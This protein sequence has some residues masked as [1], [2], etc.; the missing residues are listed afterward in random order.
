MSSTIKD[1]ASIA[2]VSIATVS[3]V[4]NGKPGIKPAT[5]QIVLKTAKDLNYSPDY[6]ARS[7]ITKRTSTIA[8]V[9]ADTANPFYADTAKT[10]ERIA[11][12]NDYSLIVCNTDNKASIQK[13]I[14]EMLKQKKVDGMIFG[15]V[16][17]SDPPVHELIQEG[18]PCILYHRALK[19]SEGN[20]IGSDNEKGVNLVIN[21]LY[22]LGHRRIGFISGPSIFS[23]GMERLSSYINSIKKLGLEHIPYLVQEGGYKLTKTTVAVKKLINLPSPPTAIFAS[24]DFMALQVMD[25]ILKEGYR[26]P[27]DF[28][29]VGY[30]N[31]LFAS[32]QRIQLTTVDVQISEAARLAIENLLNIINRK[33]EQIKPIKIIIE[34][35]LV[36]RASTSTPKRI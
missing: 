10:I 21:H 20:F 16:R 30:D 35:K 4:L 23:T 11:R 32:H 12:L 6:V 31:I 25:I 2:G 1:V 33:S 13:K 17:L 26:I 15:S 27:E 36:I 18:Y 34:P 28:S 14:I 9:I 8:L 5:I 22:K 19:N 3:R 24:N 29:I 7:M